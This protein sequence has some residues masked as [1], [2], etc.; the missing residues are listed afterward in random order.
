MVIWPTAPDMG[1]QEDPEGGDTINGVLM[2]AGA[3]VGY[4]AWELHW[5]RTIHANDAI[6]FIQDGRLSGKMNRNCPE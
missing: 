5:W 2:P 6:S 3:D 4:G 1:F